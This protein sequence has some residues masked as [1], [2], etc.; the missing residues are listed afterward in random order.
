MRPKGK[1]KSEKIIRRRYSKE[2]FV[3]WFD[4]REEFFV[5]ECKDAEDIEFDQLCLTTCTVRKSKSS[6][7]YKTVVTRLLK[8]RISPTKL[9]DRQRRRKWRH[10]SDLG[11]KK[12]KTGI[13][14]LGSLA[15]STSSRYLIRKIARNEEICALGGW[16]TCTLLANKWT[17]HARLVTP[18][19][20]SS[21]RRNRAKKIRD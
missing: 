19:Q 11:G 18:L 21:S 7:C 14:E 20:A 16:H 2:H 1:K 9:N 4:E 6:S 15:K 3:Y 12:K 8:T 10:V 17:V 5:A 13:A